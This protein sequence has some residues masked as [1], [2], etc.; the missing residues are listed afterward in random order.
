MGHTFYARQDSPGPGSQVDKGSRLDH[1]FHMW[2]M[3]HFASEVRPVVHAPQQ[4]LE[5]GPFLL[6]GRQLELR[7]GRSLTQANS[8]TANARDI[9]RYERRDRTDAQG[10]SGIMPQ[11]VSGR[12][13]DGRD[14]EQRGDGHDIL[15]P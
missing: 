1:G 6:Y 7:E 13:G 14:E 10:H 5:A 2:D 8:S 3:A 9:G 12:R 4:P 15:R 11:S